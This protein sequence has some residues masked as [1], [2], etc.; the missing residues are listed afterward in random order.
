MGSL[1]L[2][3]VDPRGWDLNT[4]LA[5]F[6]VQI[7]KGAKDEKDAARTTAALSAEPIEVRK[8][9][10]EAERAGKVAPGGGARMT[11]DA[12]E[13][14]LARFAAADEAFGAG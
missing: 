9:R 11:V 7:R 8:Q 1:A 13:A 10:R 6:E 4:M 14:M 2:A 12:A 5:A 3:G